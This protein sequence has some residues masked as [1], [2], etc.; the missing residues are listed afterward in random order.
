MSTG[1]AGYLQGDQDEAPGCLMRARGLE[2][3]LST[4]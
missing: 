4:E 3:R 1:N 2:E